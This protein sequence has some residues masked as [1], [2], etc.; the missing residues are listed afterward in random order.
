MRLGG[1]RKNMYL[2]GVFSHTHRSRRVAVKLMPSY[3]ELKAEGFSLRSLANP[4][5]I[6]NYIDLGT[7]YAVVKSWLDHPPVKFTRK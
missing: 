1:L 3:L 6:T 4:R 5:E 2:N 7:L